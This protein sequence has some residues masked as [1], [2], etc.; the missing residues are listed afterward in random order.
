MVARDPY[1]PI[2]LLLLGVPGAVHYYILRKLGG[3]G[4]A[5]VWPWS[6]VREYAHVR[7]VREWPRW[8]LYAMW[9]SLLVGISFLLVGVSKL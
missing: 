5:A 2:G 4:F 3:S 8:P 9:V 6:Y 7:A 1:L